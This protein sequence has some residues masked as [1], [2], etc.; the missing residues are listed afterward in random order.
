[1]SELPNASDALECRSDALEAVERLLEQRPETID[2]ALI[3]TTR[4]LVR[5]RDEMI[6][7]LRIDASDAGAV[8]ELAQANGA[9]SLVFGTHYPLVGLEWERLQKVRDALAELSRQARR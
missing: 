3:S 5:Y 6:R 2:A 1:M 9:L 8:R 7:R 4:C